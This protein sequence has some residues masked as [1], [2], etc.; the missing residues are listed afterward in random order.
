MKTKR[1]AACFLV[2]ICVAASAWAFTPDE[3][4]AVRLVVDD[5]VADLSSVPKT[6]GILILPI[7]GDQNQYVEGQLKSAF[8]GAGYNVVEPA[9]QI[10]WKKILAEIEWDERKEDILDADTLVKFGDIEGA[11]FVVYGSLL[12][13]E[14]TPERIFAELAL[15]ASSLSTRQH[16][17]GGDFAKSFYLSAEIRGIVDFDKNAREVLAALSAKIVESAKSAGDRPTGAVVMVP[18]P[19]DRDGFITAMVRDALAGAGVNVRNLNVRT[20]AQAQKLLRDDPAQA[21]AILS[22]AVRDLSV[23]VRHPVPLKQT[24]EIQIAVQLGIQ[25]ARG[26]SIWGGVFDETRTFERKATVWEFLRTVDAKI[27]LYV[28]GALVAL[29]LFR[30]FI[31]ANTRVR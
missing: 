9:N 6:E 24:D 4:Q 14:Q 26:Q 16:A 1:I 15:H 17:W 18:L 21:D 23:A 11:K 30:K 27:W 20:L 25:D 28:G 7:H 19:G 29:I 8:S 22:G 2:S 5:A 3:R 12:Q 13:V 31:K 10:V